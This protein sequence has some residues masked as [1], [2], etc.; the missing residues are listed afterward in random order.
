MSIQAI[1]R[2]ISTKEVS[3][4]QSAEYNRLRKRLS[5]I[6]AEL[7]KLEG[8]TDE[9]SKKKRAKLLEDQKITRAQKKRAQ[10]TS[11]LKALS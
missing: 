6:A 5:D 3:V 8:K 9:L 1:A 4:T 7:K 11:D 2:L 10:T